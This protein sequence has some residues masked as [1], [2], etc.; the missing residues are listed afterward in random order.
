MERKRGRLITSWVTDIAKWTGL[1]YPDVVRTGQDRRRWK[2][3]SSN[4]RPVN[5]TWKRNFDP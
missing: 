3:V 4:P 2:A 5:G 1:N